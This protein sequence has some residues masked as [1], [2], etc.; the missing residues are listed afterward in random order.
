MMRAYTLIVQRGSNSLGNCNGK[1]TWKMFQKIPETDYFS[2]AEQD[3]LEEIT[4]LHRGAFC[5]SSFRCIYYYDSNKSTGKETGK[6]HLCALCSDARVGERKKVVWQ[7]FCMHLICT[8]WPKI[9]SLFFNSV[10]N[11]RLCIR[12]V[13]HWQLD[14]NLFELSINRW[15]PNYL[16]LF[17]H[18]KDSTSKL[19]S[20]QS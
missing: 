18:W 15:R 3:S 8:L 17:M 1:P 19:Q 13:M 4:A 7:L 12:Q 16:Y 9:H 11:V 20:Q 6:T 5:Q 10:A 2:N 14:K